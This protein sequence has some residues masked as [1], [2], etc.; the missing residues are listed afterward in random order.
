M[1]LF[2]CKSLSSL[3]WVLIKN[4][5]IIPI[6]KSVQRKC[7][8]S[9]LKIISCAG[10]ACNQDA[11]LSAVWTWTETSDE[12]LCPRSEFSVRVNWWQQTNPRRALKKEYHSIEAN[13]K[14]LRRAPRM[15]CLLG[16]PQTL[17]DPLR[18]LVWNAGCRNQGNDPHW[19]S[20]LY[21]ALSCHDSSCFHWN[22]K[23][24]PSQPTW[25]FRVPGRWTSAPKSHF[26]MCLPAHLTVES[27]C[28]CGR[29]EEAVR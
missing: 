21:Q 12:R 6:K 4:L 29:R 14:C 15:G 22:T 27:V 26:K 7:S 13:E 16:S 10:E 2:S 18:P 28:G 17:P 25:G 3:F 1:L 20:S 19:P 24:A 5:F 11:V 9:L 23:K 8:P